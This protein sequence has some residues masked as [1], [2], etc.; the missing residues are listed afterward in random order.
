MPW[1]SAQAVRTILLLLAVALLPAECL[2][3]AGSPNFCNTWLKVCNR[4]CPNGPG[5]CTGVCA[6][7]YQ[8]CLS[9]GCFFFNVPGPRCQG[10]TKDETATGKANRTMKEGKTI[11]CG[12]RFGG[13]A[14]D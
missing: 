1:S 3:A 5:S 10:N 13:R 7:R 6:G 14:C 8:G 2:A 4:T 11:G 12:P 9:S